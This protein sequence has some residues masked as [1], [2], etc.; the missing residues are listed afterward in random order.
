M[1]VKKVTIRP[2]RVADVPAVCKMMK[3]LATSFGDK[4]KIT[5]RDLF[6]RC[7]GR[8]KLATVFLAQI[9]DKLIGF[10]L[11][12]EWWNFYLGIK[13]R[14]IDFLFVEK[15]YRS[16]GTGSALIKFVMQDA[17]KKDCV[18]LDIAA[19]IENKAANNLYRKMGFQQRNKR[20]IW[21][22]MYFKKQK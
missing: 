13:I 2:M 3:G 19:G 6:M 21:Y 9:D 14:T 7:F 11:S 5:K 16:A 17:V 15:K 12:R 18:R 1:S 22:G 4:A 8:K 20:T 10:S